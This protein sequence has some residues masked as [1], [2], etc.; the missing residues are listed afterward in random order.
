MY[1]LGQKRKS[2]N[3]G[4]PTTELKNGAVLP[5]GDSLP[6]PIKSGI[7]SEYASAFAARSAGHCHDHAAD[8]RG[9]LPAAGS[10]CAELA[11]A[12]LNNGRVLPEGYR[13]PSP[14]IQPVGSPYSELNQ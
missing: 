11:D 10:P 14:P 4:D 8:F 3:L 2:T 5:Q 1:Y 9:N 6:L 7:S 12:E 13:L